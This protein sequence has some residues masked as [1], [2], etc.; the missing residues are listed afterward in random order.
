MI[1]KNWFSSKTI[2][3]NGAIVLMTGALFF[4][5]PDP[6]KINLEVIFTTMTATTNI[7]LRILTKQ[8]LK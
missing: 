7:L 3:F 6:Q 4:L 5:H 8:P 1:G 2:I